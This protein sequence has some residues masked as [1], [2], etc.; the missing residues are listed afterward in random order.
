MST[1]INFPCSVLHFH[2]QSSKWSNL[3]V[4]IWKTQK[5]EEEH[6]SNEK[7]KS[8]CSS[9]TPNKIQNVEVIK[10]SVQVTKLVRVNSQIKKK[11]ISNMRIQTFYFA[12]QHKGSKSSS[13]STEKNIMIF[14]STFTKDKNNGKQEYLLCTGTINL[15][16]K[17]HD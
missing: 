4:A 14:N 10:F 13:F 6:Q 15:L 1:H 3:S 8:K 17:R 2:L 7:R 5:L 11:H 9:A 12:Q 16:E